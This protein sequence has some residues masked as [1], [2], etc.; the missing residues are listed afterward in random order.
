ME[1]VLTPVVTDGE[2]CLG[3]NCPTIF[4][5]ESGS[6]VVQGVAVDADTRAHMNMPDS[7]DAVEVP[8]S[9]LL[10]LVSQ[11]RTSA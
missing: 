7:E 9:L 6:F 3:G 8:A 5:T 2:F 1:R 4:R 10:Q 11:L